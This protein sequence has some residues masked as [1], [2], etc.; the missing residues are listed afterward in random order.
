MIMIIVMTINAVVVTRNMKI[1]PAFLVNALKWTPIYIFF[2]SSTV[3]GRYR[4]LETVKNECPD[5][6]HSDV[7][8]AHPSLHL[9]YS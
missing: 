9:W 8:C 5:R 1:R 3:S 7:L 6:Y 2:V 4:V